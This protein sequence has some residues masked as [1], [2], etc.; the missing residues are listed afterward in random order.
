M[1]KNQREFI[2]YIGTKLITFFS[3]IFFIF[4]INNKKVIFTSYTGKQYSCNPKYISEYLKKHYGHDFSVVWVL[5]E[6]EKGSVEDTSV[7]FLSLKHYYNFVTSKVIVDNLGMPTYMPKRKGQ[8]VINTWHGG[9]AYKDCSSA[10]LK[11]S[12]YRMKME[13]KKTK[14]TDL[15]LSS[16][17]VFSERVVPD[18]VYKYSG[19]IMSSGMPRNDLIIHGDKAAIR[20]KVCQELNIDSGKLVVLFAPTFRGDF[21]V[22]GGMIGEKAVNL[23]LDIENVL[24]RIKDRY[25]KEA[26]L[27]FRKHHALQV[28]SDIDHVIDVSSYPDMQELLCT[29]DILISD[30]SSTIWDF[31]LT[32]KPCFLYCPDLDYYL[33][34]DRG[35]YTPVETWPGILCRTNEELKQ[36]ILNFDETAYIEKVEKHLRDLGSY[37]NGTACDQVCKRIAQVCG[38]EGKA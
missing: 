29:A 6:P 37:E 2:Q 27:L 22:I 15:V 10:S 4:P 36:A 1:N 12:K 3:K 11:K 19:E 34:E 30:Y 26:V 9:G 20:K 38:I 32:K 35:V 8:Y 13:M 7:K 24:E 33:N 31:S 28:G 14:A 17:K 5:R 18:I 21:N 23:D 25:H 16:C